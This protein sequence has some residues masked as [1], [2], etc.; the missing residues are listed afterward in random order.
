MSSFYRWEKQCGF[1]RISNLD[2]QKG[3]DS[4]LMPEPL[5]FPLGQTR[6]VSRP[7]LVHNISHALS[8]ALSQ[9]LECQALGCKR[10]YLLLT[11]AHS[12]K[13]DGHLGV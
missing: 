12:S 7:H 6:C 8:H 13:T 2:P 11:H 1:E 4:D 5:P 3:S 9:A 10:A